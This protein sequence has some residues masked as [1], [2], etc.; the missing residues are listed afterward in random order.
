MKILIFWD[1]FW[2]IWRKALE[3]ELEGLKEKYSPDFIVA[4]VDN[5]TSWRWAVEKHILEMER[6]GIDIATWWDHILDNEKYIEDY[7]EKEDGILI[8]PAN[9]YK[10]A[11][12]KIPWKWYKIVEKNWKRLLVIQLMWEVFMKYNMYNPFLK[13]EKIQDKFKDKKINLIS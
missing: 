7:L 13:I 2:R 4:S 5:I 6:L 10:S 12:Y 9:F 11:H 3:K 8:R 1:I